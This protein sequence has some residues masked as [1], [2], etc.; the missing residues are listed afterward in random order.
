MQ[1]Q[2]KR[3]TLVGHLADEMLRE[4]SCQRTE[5]SRLGTQFEF[6]KQK[7]RFRFTKEE[8][9]ELSYCLASAVVECGHLCKITEKRQ[10]FPVQHGRSVQEIRG[11]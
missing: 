2:N 4:L 8:L 9:K 11:R 10:A 6:I 3:P 5:L 1:R 7:A